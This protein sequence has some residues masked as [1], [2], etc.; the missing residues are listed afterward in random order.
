MDFFG[1]LLIG[2]LTILGEMHFEEL[3]NGFNISHINGTF[4]RKSVF[5]V[6]VDLNFQSMIG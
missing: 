1:P 5:Q 4:W 2:E 3:V 6:Y